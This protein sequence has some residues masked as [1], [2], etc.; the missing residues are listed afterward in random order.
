MDAV[1]ETR[2]MFQAIFKLM[3]IGE[4]EEVEN[5]LRRVRRLVVRSH[6]A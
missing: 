5:D 4:M 2:G 1:L 6:Q 3:L